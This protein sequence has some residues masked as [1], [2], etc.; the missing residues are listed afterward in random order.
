MLSV[1][2]PLVTTLP[3]AAQSTAAAAAAA[4][5]K[6]KCVALHRPEP[7][8]IT[9]VEQAPFVK[10][11]DPDTEE[12]LRDSSQWT[13]F[14]IDLLTMIAE[15]CNFTFSLQLPRQRAP[16]DAKVS[17]NATGGGGA[18]YNY[19]FLKSQTANYGAGQRDVWEDHSDMFFSGYYST[20]QRMEAGVMTTAVMHTPLSI[21]TRG[22][23]EVPPWTAFLKPFSWGIWGSWLLAA[24]MSGAVFWVLEA[25]KAGADFGTH[26]GI[27]WQSFRSNIV[28]SVWLSWSATTGAASHTPGTMLGKCFSSIWSLFCIVMM[29]SY[30][31]S[32]AAHLVQRDVAAEVSGIEDLKRTGAKLCVQNNTAYAKSL[33]KDHSLEALLEY[34]DD[35]PAMV[36]ALM[37]DRR[38]AAMAHLSANMNYEMATSCRA[39]PPYAS[40][41]VGVGVFND[42]DQDMS[43]GLQKRH[44]VARD[45][46]SYHIT[47]LRHSGA[48]DK[49][50]RTYL[51]AAGS[52]GCSGVGGGSKDGNSSLQWQN[53]YGVFAALFVTA[54]LCTSTR[55]WTRWRRLRGADKTLKGFLFTNFNSSR[56]TVQEVVDH[57]CRSWEMRFVMH[58]LV[59]EYL[60]SNDVAQAELWES[61]GARI[62]DIDNVTL[63][64]A[65][66]RSQH[67]SREVLVRRAMLAFVP[68]G[69]TGTV[70]GVVPRIEIRCKMLAEVARYNVARRQEAEVNEARSTVSEGSPRP[71]SLSPVRALRSGSAT[72]RSGGA[73]LHNAATRRPSAEIAAQQRRS[74]E[75]KREESADLQQRFGQDQAYQHMFDEQSAML[76]EIVGK[77][78]G[79]IL[80]RRVNSTMTM[81][82]AQAALQAKLAGL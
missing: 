35:V 61:R 33:S 28:H 70:K 48:I 39:S 59:T 11:R 47:A 4:A 8:R 53:M 14:S 25:G 54:A 7:W 68:G 66:V 12:P 36:K 16:A 23:E 19:S 21:V 63:Q 38:C 6:A 43:V 13:G 29:A 71:S 37:V 20:P 55:F 3:V 46:L 67:H 45:E 41:M 75:R 40:S 9:V 32:L 27:S 22:N 49:L 30:T 62:R 79:D 2:L 15:R 81:P 5:I 26:S 1:L 50:E 10:V 51:V 77:V 52:T 76:T 73:A 18:V 42:L 34:F 60:R 24:C 69:G 78:R 72:L 31:A 80:H 65:N 56:C 82:V 57:W 44:S 17:S 64:S 74:S 58:P